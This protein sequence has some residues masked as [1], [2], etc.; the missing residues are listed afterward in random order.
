VFGGFSFPLFRV[1][2]FDVR[3]HWSLAAFVV[4]MGI[5]YGG[6]AGV[7][8]ATVLF[9]SVLLHELGHSVVARARRVP[10]EG[11]EL[12]F[13]GGV[14]K[15]KAPP[16]SPADEVA[17]AIAGP[18]V[19]LALAL[20]FF[21]AARFFPDVSVLDWAAGMNLSLGLFNLLPALP[22]DGGRV[23]RALLA[24]RHGLVG[25][26]E[27]AVKTSRVIAIGLG[28][29]GVFTNVWLIALAVLVWVLGSSERA[30][31]RRHEILRRMGFRDDDVDPWARYARAA[32]RERG[33]ALVPD[34][35]ETGPLDRHASP[36]THQRLVRDPWGNFVVVT[37]VIR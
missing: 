29:L 15:M 17:I 32:E 19:S 20:A 8:L 13:F 5:A 28:V 36:R 21:V 12:H 9:A 33:G 3:A 7:V 14:A 16:R 2:G 34:V 37:E 10:I 23:L 11:I 1:L 26:T 25:G 24:R 6:V 4:L 31:M 22:M 30:Q 18:L 35:I 27:R